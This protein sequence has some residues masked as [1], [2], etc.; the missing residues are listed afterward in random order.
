MVATMAKQL[1]VSCLADSGILQFFIVKNLL[2]RI[3]EDLTH[4]DLSSNFAQINVWI[5]EFPC[6][7]FIHPNRDDLTV[8]STCRGISSF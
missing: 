7:L 8:S 3:V 6:F 1:S 2:I 5:T 4:P